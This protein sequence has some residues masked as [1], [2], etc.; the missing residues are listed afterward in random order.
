[1]EKENVPQT[2][3]MPGDISSVALDEKNFKQ[4]TVLFE[5]NDITCDFED[6]GE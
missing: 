1:M 6:I 2:S 3:I 4:R 5:N